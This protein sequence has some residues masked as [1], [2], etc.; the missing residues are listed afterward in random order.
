MKKILVTLCDA[1]HE[2][3]QNHEGRELEPTRH[4]AVGSTT[5]LVNS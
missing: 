2:T 4:P 1:G 5:Y 3:A